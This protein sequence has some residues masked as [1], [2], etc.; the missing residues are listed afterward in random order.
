MLLA[1]I[2]EVNPKRYFHY[3]GQML[4]LRLEVSRRITHRLATAVFKLFLQEVLGYPFVTI[5]EE[6]DHFNT[7]HTMQRLSGPLTNLA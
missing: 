4:D 6:D 1:L 5:V 2:T 3:E 7:T